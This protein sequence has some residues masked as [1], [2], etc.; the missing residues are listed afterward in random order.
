MSVP[1][2][3]VQS[4]SFKSFKLVS[5]ILACPPKLLMWGCEGNYMSTIIVCMQLSHNASNNIMWI[6][7]LNQITWTPT[8]QTI[9]C[10][11]KVTVSSWTAA[12]S[13][14]KNKN[15]GGGVV[16][17]H[18]LSQFQDLVL[19]EIRDAVRFAGIAVGNDLTSAQR[20]SV[21]NKMQGHPT[22]VFCKISVRRSK[23]CLE[24]SIAWIRLKISRW[25][26]H[27]GTIFE[28][29]LK[30]SLWISEV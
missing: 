1:S 20:T 29:H 4:E 17:V 25:A 30:N 21:F 2:V 22:T 8:P 12:P 3:P 11:C 19:S 18:R 15:E 23:F 27:S 7:I 5:S 9:N 14:Q 10:Q 16:A 13:P 6:S 24:F 28:A 26:F